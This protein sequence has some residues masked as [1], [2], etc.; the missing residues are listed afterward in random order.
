MVQ[1]EQWKKQVEFTSAFHWEL[2]NQ[3]P[4]LHSLQD[5]LLSL[6]VDI[7]S[8][9]FLPVPRPSQV[10]W[11]HNEILGEWEQEN[12]TSRSALPECFS[13]SQSQVDCEESGSSNNG[14]EDPPGSDAEVR[15]RTDAS[16]EN[17]KNRTVGSGSVQFG[18]QILGCQFGSRFYDFLNFENW[19]RTS[20][21]QTFCTYFFLI[22]LLRIEWDIINY[23]L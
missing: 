4:L 2:L 15:F 3:G 8:N 21:N 5:L 10:D 22:F 11:F 13:H 18:P 19:V 6:M 7:A 16:T 23:Q 17:R 1:Q 9:G 20:S 14:P 12:H